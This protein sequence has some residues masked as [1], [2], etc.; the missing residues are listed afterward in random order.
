MQTILEWGYAQ[1]G[2]YGAGLILVSLAVNILVL[3]LYHVA[4]VWQ[5]AERAVQNRMAWQTARIKKV[6]RGKE[7][8]LLMQELY[9]QHHYHPIMAVRT[10]VGVLIQIP[11]FFAAF[12]LLNNY[13]P[14]QGV[15]LG[16]IADLGKPDALCF[17]LNVLPFLMTAI[18]LFSAQI[19]TT[20]LSRRDKI[21]AYGLAAVFL[22]LLYSSAAGLLFYWT[23]NNI[24][25]LLKNIVYERL[26]IFGHGQEGKNGSE[27]KWYAPMTSALSRM[28][29]KLK[30]A[31]LDIL[32]AA[33]I[34]L[35]IGF[36]LFWRGALRHHPDYSFVMSAMLFGAAI[37]VLVLGYFAKEHLAL[38]KIA[39]LPALVG[40][41]GAVVLT[42]LYAKYGF[43]QKS[44]KKIALHLGGL[45]I[46]SVCGLYYDVVAGWISSFA[47]RIGTN[48]LVV[49]ASLWVN[50]SNVFFHRSLV[51]K[52]LLLIAFCIFVYSPS[53]II[54]ADEAFQNSIVFAMLTGG[55]IL[56]IVLP[57]IVWKIAPRIIKIILGYIYSIIAIICVTYTFFLIKDYG[58]LKNL[59]FEYSDKIFNISYIIIDIIVIS[60]LIIA[61]IILILYNKK[62]LN[63][64]I[65]ISIVGAV[66]FSG[67]SYG[68]ILFDFD[69]Q[70]ND[71]QLKSKYIHLSK[72]KNN[73]LVIMI[74][75]F[76]GDHMYKILK[77]RP[78]I[79]FGFDGFTWYP[80]TISAANCTSM[81]LPSLIGGENI[82]AY[83][84]VT[85]DGKSLEEKVDKEIRVFFEYL[86]KK[87]F[88][89]KIVASSEINFISKQN[90]VESDISLKLYPY[91]SDKSADVY[92]GVFS[93]LFGLFEAL[94]WSSRHLIYK[95]GSWNI[96]VKKRTSR[97]VGGEHQYYTMKKL[98][99]ITDT[100]S[101]N[102]HYIFF[103][104]LLAHSPWV[105]NPET[106]TPMKGDPCP[107]TKKYAERLDGV[108]PE[109]Y[110][111]EQAT[112]KLLSI[113]FEWLKREGVYDNTCI[114]VVS[115]HDDGDSQTLAAAFGTPNPKFSFFPASPCALLMVKPL[116]SHGELQVSD[117]LMSTT[118]VRKIAEAV[119]A[120]R[121]YTASPDA[122]RIRYH[123][124][125][126]SWNR[127]RHPK[128][129]YN[130][131]KLH[132]ITGPKLKRENWVRIK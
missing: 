42:Y 90:Y 113:Y 60:S 29:E 66:C 118:D 51:L 122:H 41:L 132:K 28:P 39:L 24:F 117:A 104:S 130:V 50:Q 7:R 63:T 128:N 53:R 106:L 14:M 43:S 35:A 4:E 85:D 68:K 72:E 22:V 96:S 57:Y 115:D 49:R 125:G 98:P 74:D 107:E 84:L 20:R 95:D 105:I 87:N 46:L 81:S 54:V 129:Y 45:G 8:F 110:Y 33:F 44:S 2:S 97:L 75:S 32:H 76:T 93:M 30:N 99:D 26:G 36:F 80:D 15:S 114:I 11:F 71:T 25:A 116:Q 9:R 27:K 123:A 112:L 82:A 12:H 18:N 10:S 52:S 37:L 16:P 17:G 79:L 67:I 102:S 13:A 103:T 131:T 91:S 23:W 101:K 108:I 64:I 69:G 6:F 59:I 34:L 127:N 88:S 73:I 70:Q 3:P 92:N 119:A 77:E 31:R 47:K 65:S 38:R 100:N 109:H 48:A 124:C 56:T 58:V 86:H 89:T 78:E 94:P 55:F 1:T 111:A 40:I 121:T 126:I 21:Q 120:G 83:N 19:Y 61:Q 5:D 62:I